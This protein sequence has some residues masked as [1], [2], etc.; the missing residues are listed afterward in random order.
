MTNR[1]HLPGVACP[2]I[3]R[4]VGFENLPRTPAGDIHDTPGMSAVPRLLQGEE[5]ACP[6]CQRWDYDPSK[7]LIP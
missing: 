3:G 1:E 4:S 6:R 5:A 7:L 2:P